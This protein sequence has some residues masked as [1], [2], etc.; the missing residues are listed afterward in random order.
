MPRDVDFCSS[1]TLRD[2]YAT[3]LRRLLT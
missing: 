2:G 3:V 1:S